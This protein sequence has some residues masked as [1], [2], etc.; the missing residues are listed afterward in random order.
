MTHATNLHDST[1]ILTFEPGTGFR[2]FIAG[3]GRIFTAIPVDGTAGFAPNCICYDE[4]GSAQ[5]LWFNEG[6]NTSCKFRQEETAVQLAAVHQIPLIDMRV[7]GTG[8][9]LGN[10]A[11]GTA[12]LVMGTF[13]TNT[14]TVVGNAANNNSKTDK[15]RFNIPVPKNYNSGGAMSVVINAKVGTLLTVA[16]TIQAKVVKGDEAGG[17]TADLATGGAQVLTTSYADYTWTITTTGFVAGD[18]LDIEVTLLADDTGGA[19]ND[20]IT[21]GAVEVLADLTA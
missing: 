8:A 7:T 15:F 1:G 21:V 14:P 12:G 11:S 13:L 4:T 20:K 19:V 3:P 16:N 17:V 5:E 18:L 6:S 9:I 10:V 2:E